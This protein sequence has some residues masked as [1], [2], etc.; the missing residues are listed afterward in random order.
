[1]T[2]APDGTILSAAGIQKRFGALVV[3]DDIDFAMGADEAVGIVGP[4]GAGKTTLLSVL[5]GAYP[6][7]AGTIA[8]NTILGSASALIQDSDVQ[9]TAAVTVSAA[10]SAD[11][12]A[13]IAAAAASVAG[14]FNSSG[15]AIAVGIV[16]AF[17][18]VGYSGSI[19]EAGQAKPLK[20]EA[21]IRNS[22]VDG[23][24]VGV[25]A[26]SDQTIDA[27]TVA[28][29]VAVGLSG[30]GNG[31]TVSAGGVFVQNSIAA[32]TTAAIDSGE[33]GNGRST[34]TAGDD[35][36][37]VEA[38]NTSEIHSTAAAASLAASLAGNNAVAVS[39]GLAVALN[40]IK[41]SVA[42]TIS[43]ADIASDGAVSVKAGN[44]AT[45]EAIGA[46]ASVAASLSPTA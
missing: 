24:G 41:G 38:L 1:M 7:S 4:N 21:R 37:D 29:S 26:T 45:I 28:G 43:Q 30:S 13:T 14:G 8:F 34:I 44:E 22:S 36:L 27:F 25:S 6:P 42:A 35:G 16:L 19:A 15:T 17:N 31:I 3:L 18:Y 23:S 46:S 40:D 32:N 10:N 11:I 2:N 39:I 20:T 12:D 9:A 33:N 5:S